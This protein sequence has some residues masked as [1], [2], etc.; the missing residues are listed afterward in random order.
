MVNALVRRDIKRY[1]SNPTGYVFIT[2]FIFM[3]AAAAFWPDRFFLNNLAT[4]D[5]LNAFFPF[6]LLFFV[7][8]IT[9]GVWADERQQ[10]TDELLLTL[11]ATDL[12]VVLGKYLSTLGIYAAAL[13]L[14][15]SHLVVLFW[16]GNP[17]IGLMLSN[18]I[19]YFLIGAAFVSVGGVASLLSPNATIAFILG[20]VFCS[21]F[22]FAAS[23]ANVFGTSVAIAVLPLAVF[24]HFGEFARGIVSFSGVLY[25]ISIVGTMLYLS[26]VVLG[27]RHWPREAGGYRM[28]VHQATRVVSVF[29]AVI[30]FNV[31]AGRTAIRLDFTAEKLHS[32]TKQTREILKNIPDDRPV[33]IQAFLSKDV[34]ASFVE[35]R[36]N[37]YGFLKEVD[38]LG[39]DKVQ[40]LIH[41]TEP[42]SPE[43]IDAREKFGIIPRNMPGTS[44]RG[45][46]QQVFLGVAVTCGAEEEVIQHFDPGLSPEY[47]LVRSIRVVAR[48]GRK[49]I[50]V[51]NTVLKMFG[52]L[53][54][55]T[56]QSQPAWA[57]VDELRKQ[58]EVIQ[59]SATDSITSDL[60]GLV[61][62]LPSA[63]PQEEMDIVRAYVEAGNPTLFL[64][65]PLLTLNIALSPAEKSGASRSPF[66]RNQGPPPKDKGDIDGLM[67]EL[68]VEWGKTQVVWDG[69]NPHPDLASLPP[70]IVFVGAGNQNPR[71]FNRMFRATEG[72]QEIVFLYP[73]TITKPDGSPFTFE[74]LIRT[75]FAS[76]VLDYNQ[77]VQRSFFG[78]QLSGRGLPHYASNEDYTI[79]AR[80]TGEDPA[81]NRKVNL[82]V[83]A[84]IDFASEQFFEIRR[85]GIETLNFDNISF[86]LNC[87]DMLVGDESFIALRN[88]R[89]K[90]RTLESVEARIQAFEKEREAE[91]Q[92]ANRE[93]GIAL[94]DAQ[95]RL[96][97]KVA[98]LQ[99]RTDLDEQTKT[100]MTRNLQ[101]SESRRFEAMKTNIDSERDMKI[102]R[103]QESMESHIRSIRGN[104]KTLAAVLPPIPVLAMGVVI[105]LRRRN[106]EIE[107]AAAA[108][109]LKG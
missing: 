57:V 96:N 69:Y 61:V 4:L 41:D 70:E 35:T 77:M 109:R 17:D 13:V 78:V 99:Q 67:R 48:T 91:V 34:P 31:F 75:G 66:S 38:A 63:L 88:R 71:S 37:L 12:E 49:K 83:V 102:Q 79:A 100:I 106:R 23:L 26:V 47:E 9:M 107:G 8:A 50:G 65:D 73:G 89:V 2:L 62:A 98:E 44:A 27:R 20:A 105:F 60:D 29:V 32:V 101:E 85:R 6:L 51:L 74:P 39:G 21:F 11:P 45:S 33:L 30:A 64:I 58:Y 54:F 16:L 15:L 55:T 68:G 56:F 52:G 81:T 46:V 90:H 7:P 43:A 24:E 19:G 1:F 72:L 97:A 82:I 103:T 94:N 42:F 10:G 108:R 5:Q 36:T 3:S 84:D 18:Y 25:F 28:S 53:D 93:A 22:V 95:R 59:I 87:I 76:G 92:E 40:V 14:S 80:V 86:F 104:I